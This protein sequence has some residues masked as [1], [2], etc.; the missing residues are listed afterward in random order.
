MD[1]PG[2]RGTERPTLRCIG[3][4]TID[5]NEV[6]L[7]RADVLDKRKWSDG[8]NYYSDPKEGEACG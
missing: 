6:A 2:K 4:M 8:Q 7:T 1:L 3:C 5:I